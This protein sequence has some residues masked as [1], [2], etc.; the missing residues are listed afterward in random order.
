ML[1]TYYYGPQNTIHS[2]FLGGLLFSNF[3][4][5]ITLSNKISIK[6]LAGDLSEL[7]A[8]RKV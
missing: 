4:N 2:N 5:Y 3:V 7:F 8:F 6:S 1:A